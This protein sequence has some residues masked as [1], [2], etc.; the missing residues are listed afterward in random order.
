MVEPPHTVGGGV[1]RGLDG[2]AWSCDSKLCQAIPESVGVKSEDLCCPLFTF[3]LPIT[4]PQDIQD[5]LSL[6]HRQRAIRQKS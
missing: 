1:E 3:H 5:V 6:D 4:L 2:L